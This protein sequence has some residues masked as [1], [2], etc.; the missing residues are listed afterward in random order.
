MS[1]LEICPKENLILR[2]RE[3]I[4]TTPIE[5]NVQ[6]AGVTEEDQIF[7]SDDDEKTEE[8][9]LAMEK[10]RKSNPTSQL[11]D[12]SLEKLSKHIS[13]YFETPILQKLA[14]PTT[15]AIE[16][17][18]D[19]ILQQLCLKIQK[20]EYS[21]FILQQDP[22]YRHYC[23]QLDCLTVQD[24]IIIRDYCDETGCIQ[25]RQVLFPKHFVTERLQSLH[26][27]ANHPGISKMLLE[28]R[29]KYNYPGIAKFSKKWD[30]ECETCIK[31]ESRIR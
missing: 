10:R 30:K 7:Y 25:Y 18:N 6:S 27:T 19:I 3:N 9:N 13:A 2:I 15:M 14:K 28:I 12:I 11:P 5:L 8:S 29:P 1:R 16:Q 22:L 17:Q 4:S 31:D 23:S 26:K 20:E 21:E 24:D